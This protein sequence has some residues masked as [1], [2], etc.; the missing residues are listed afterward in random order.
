[1]LNNH[2][3]NNKTIT[4]SQDIAKAYFATEA[5]FPKNTFIHVSMFSGNP[6]L[7]GT[8]N[9]LLTR[10]DNKKCI[11]GTHHPKINEVT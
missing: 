3:E 11:V 2:Q 7:Y 10:S 6:E 8:R 9:I 1:M 4:T 5:D